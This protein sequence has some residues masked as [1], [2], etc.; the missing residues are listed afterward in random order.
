MITQF[1]INKTKLPTL[2]STTIKSR[3]GFRREG[4]FQPLM[5]LSDVC[6]IRAVFDV[7]EPSRCR[8]DQWTC[9]NGECIDQAQRCDRQ[10]HCADGTDEFDCGEYLYL[11]LR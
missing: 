8:S 6:G 2:A 11:S 7:V 1:I 9:G 3:H 5:V 10:Y 4:P